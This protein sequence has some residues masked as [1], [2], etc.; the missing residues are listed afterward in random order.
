MADGDN[1]L[2]TGALLTG[3]N[4]WKGKATGWLILWATYDLLAAGLSV[5]LALRMTGMAA[6]GSWL[7]HYLMYTA[8]WP[9]L[10]FAF[11]TYR[12]QRLGPDRNGYL[13]LGKAFLIYL[14]LWA[15]VVVFL[16]LPLDRFFFILLASSLFVLSLLGQIV[17]SSLPGAP[18][19]ANGSGR[20]RLVVLG[21]GR[22]GRD[23]VRYLQEHPEQGIEVV[24][25]LDDDPHKAGRTY[26]GARVLGPTGLLLDLV[27]EHRVD[28]VAVALPPD[29]IGLIQEVAATCMDTGKPVSLVLNPVAVALEGEPS[30][31]GALALAE[32]IAVL[33]LYPVL[34]RVPSLAAKR[35][36]DVVVSTLGLV[37]LSPV[38]LVLAVAIKLDSPGPVFFKHRRVGQGGRLFY[39]WKFRTMVDGADKILEKWLAEN[40]AIKEEFERGFKLKND[41]R[42]TRLGDFLRRTSLDELPQLINVL[43]G[44]MSLVGPRPVVRE[45][46]AKYGPYAPFLVRVLPGLTGL[47]QANGRSDTDYEERVR[48]DMEYIQNWSFWL[49]VKILLQTVPA[50]LRRRG[51]C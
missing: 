10:L 13:R 26:H 41:P 25:F 49:D 12:Y 51:A 43:K 31:Y 36:L 22:R 14:G 46:L 8:V 16:A 27:T 28:E 19:N 44:E 30:T 2:R 38:F 29:D 3:R 17:F 18:L 7:P 40:P 39:M 9:A 48:L 32:N 21:A 11:G 50:V 6:A 24:G 4:G 47:W 35:F 33:D 34:D 1:G 37:L 45:E 42:I 5:G 23:L 15:A 20:S